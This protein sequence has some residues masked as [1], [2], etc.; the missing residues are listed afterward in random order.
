MLRTYP[1]RP[2][3]HVPATVRVRLPDPAPSLT[4]PPAAHGDPLARRHPADLV[5]LHVA[6]D[7]AASHGGRRR[8]AG[9]WAAGAPRRRVARGGPAPAR[10]RGAALPPH[11]QGADP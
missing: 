6:H 3:P 7:A 5:A 1:A 11:L 9:R 8:P 10:R 2:S 4:P